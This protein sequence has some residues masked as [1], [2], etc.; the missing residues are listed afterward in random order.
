MMTEEQKGWNGFER[1]YRVMM[2]FIVFGPEG[3]SPAAEE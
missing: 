3:S 2:N 1:W